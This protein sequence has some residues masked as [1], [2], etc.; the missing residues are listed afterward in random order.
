MPRDPQ[1]I[2]RLAGAGNRHD[3]FGIAVV[4]HVLDERA[5]TIEE[6]GGRSPSRDQAAGAQPAAPEVPRRDRRDGQ[7]G[8]EHRGDLGRRPRPRPDPAG[9]E[10]CRTASQTPP[11][12]PAT[13]RPAR[14]PESSA[15]RATM[16]AAVVRTCWRID[17][18]PASA[19]CRHCL[20]W[21]RRISMS[22]ALPDLGAHARPPR[23]P[24]H[25]VLHRALAGTQSK[26]RLPHP[27]GEIGV[28]AIGAR[29]ALVEAADPLQ[30]GP[31]IGHVRRGPP[32][33]CESAD[34]ALPVR[35]RPTRRSGNDDAALRSALE[36]LHPRRDRWPDRPA[37]PVVGRRRRRGTPSTSH[38]PARQPRLRAAAGPLPADRRTVTGIGKSLPAGRAR[39]HPAGDRRRRT[40]ARA[41]A[42]RLLPARAASATSDGRP[43]V[44]TTTS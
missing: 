7:A 25:R 39:V 29:E 15:A 14:W 23:G 27:Q 21:M 20:P 9:A 19:S 28:L 11:A 38:R 43:I 37:S 13:S 16:P 6:H 3:P 2:E 35:R 42:R 44:G 26:A 40:A 34:V 5:V 31:A 36:P 10:G 8:G 22:S 4:R 33:S 32:R 17:T 41:T 18:G 1:T 12:M 24:T 30:C